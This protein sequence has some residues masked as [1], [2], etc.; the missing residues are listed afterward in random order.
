MADVDQKPQHEKLP[1]LYGQEVCGKP[2]RLLGASWE[3][4]KSDY[5]YRE[6]HV[7]ARRVDP[8]KPATAPGNFQVWVDGAE[9][10]SGAWQDARY[11]DYDYYLV[12]SSDGK[13][14]HGHL[15]DESAAPWDAGNFLVDTI[16]GAK[17]VGW[18]SL[19]EKPTR[20]RRIKR[21]ELLPVALLTATKVKEKSVQRVKLELTKTAGEALTG[22]TNAIRKAGGDPAQFA[23]AFTY[24]EE[25]KQYVIE[26]DDFRKLTA[27]ELATAAEEDE[28]AKTTSLDE[29]PPPADADTVNLDAIF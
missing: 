26:E 28:A 24:K 7:F 10:G 1:T 17:V 12:K 9:K 13:E 29:L 14:Y 19:D 22:I 11:A 16:E 20:V 3:R 15:A 21:I 6:E 8:S 2:F 5:E 18:D 27:D 4:F 23:Y 25:D